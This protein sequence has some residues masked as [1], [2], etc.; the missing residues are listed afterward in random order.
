MCRYK[1]KF[2]LSLTLGDDKECKS[3]L[4]L[5]ATESFCRLRDSQ[6]R[7]ILWKSLLVVISHGKLSDFGNHC[8]D[9]HV[10]DRWCVICGATNSQSE[11]MGID[12]GD[13]VTCT[14]SFMWPANTSSQL[15]HFAKTFI[16]YQSFQAYRGIRLGEAQNPGP[17]VGKKAPSCLN[18]AV[19]NPTSVFNK[20]GT[21]VKLRQ[22]HNIHVFALAETSVT[23]NAQAITTKQLASQKLQVNW[24]PPVL[25]Q[26]DTIKCDRGKASGTAIIS[27]VP[28]RPCRFALPDHWKTNTRFNRA[29]IQIGQSH[30]QV[31]SV[32]GYTL[33]QPRCEERTD[34]ILAFVNSQID[35]VPLPFIICGDF[36]AEVTKLPIWTSFAQRGAQD[37]AQ[38]HRQMYG[39]SVPPT[40]HQ[41]TRPDSAIVSK[42]LVPLIKAITV[43]QPTWFSAHAPVLF[44]IQLPGVAL[45]RNHFSLPKSYMDFA[46]TAIDLAEAHKFI[47]EVI[48]EPNTLEEWGQAVENTVDC[49]LQQKGES[50]GIPSYLPKSYRGRCC[51]RKLQSK[52]VISQLRHARQ[53]EY[54][55]PDEIL[56]MKTKR[57]VTQH[58]RLES[59]YRRI[60]AVPNPQAKGR[61][62]FQ[63]IC[64]EWNCILTSKCYGPP[65]ARWLADAPELGLPPWPLPSLAFLHEVLQHSRFHI[66]SAIACDRKVFQ[67]KA[68]F[69]EKL[70]RQ[71]MGARNAFSRIRGTPRSPANVI[72]KEI[73]CQIPAKWNPE[74]RTVELHHQN[75]VKL[76][77]SIPI[78]VDGQQGK[79]CHFSLDKVVIHFEK[80]PDMLPDVVKVTQSCEICKP[81]DVA[82][83]LTEYWATW[84]QS[85]SNQIADD[86][87]WEFDDALLHL[88]H[89]PPIEIDFTL[90]QLKQTISRLKPNSA[91]GFDGIS[92]YELQTL[93][94]ALLDQLLI[95]FQTY[96][97]A[98]FVSVAT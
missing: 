33:S 72:L 14:V 58:R 90:E 55:P 53:G 98:N 37:L 5:N 31:W 9:P 38:I 77:A 3:M 41:S 78:L 64:Q 63:G 2:N 25:P 7:S 44:Q 28:M 40:C 49:W 36:N 21:F 59:L 4:Q 48:P 68:K 27:A 19:V 12:F 65:F 34:D 32:Y 81:Q 83:Q 71:H 13:T 16:K 69:A 82:D 47:A 30:I 11:A 96:L 86:A 85:S 92:V 50:I 20:V 56:S 84:W 52:P 95:I 75:L 62:Y 22:Q 74:V 35:M 88:P 46:P 73:E 93:P 24:P 89:L 39:V 91:R 26:R 51:D 54:E 70:D 43:L 76:E 15:W 8:S 29:S 61:Q 67:N 57:K 94:D 42:D 18:F 10:L 6:I 23:A 79:L 17:S 45:F 1:D 87:P 60:K 66:D 80:F 97:S